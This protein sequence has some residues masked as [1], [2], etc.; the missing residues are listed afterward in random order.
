[1]IVCDA[2]D[3][4]DDDADDADDN[5]DARK[6]CAGMLFVLAPNIVSLSAIEAGERMHTLT[7]THN[8]LTHTAFAYLARSLPLRHHGPW[9]ICCAVS[10]HS[11][12]CV[13]CICVCV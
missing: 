3:D 1:M 4:D 8:T 6:T 9:T 13:R 12:L 7:Q 11:H 2:A 10:P 5:D